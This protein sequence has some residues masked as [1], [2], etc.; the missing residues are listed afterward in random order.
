L[1]VGVRQ[2]GPVYLGL[3]PASREGVEL[4]LWAVE[5]ERSYFKSV[6]G[7]ELLAELR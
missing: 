3:T 7:R 2:D 5:Q 4:E 1:H 6:F